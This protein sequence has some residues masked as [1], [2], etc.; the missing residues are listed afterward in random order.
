MH[1]ACLVALLAMISQHKMTER[2]VPRA[3]HAAGK[4]KKAGK[5]RR[6][7]LLPA[8]AVYPAVRLITVKDQL[9]NR[10]IINRNTVHVDGTAL[11]C[12]EVND[13]ERYNEA[14]LSRRW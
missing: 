4:Q 14:I 2:P 5:R 11:H 6:V 13:I 10:E 12:V 1:V 9:R 3:T 7:R 8:Y